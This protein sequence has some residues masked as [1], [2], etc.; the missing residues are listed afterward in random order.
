MTTQFTPPLAG[1]T[2]EPRLAARDL[3]VKFQ[4]KVGGFLA[5][6]NIDLSL[7]PGEFVSLVGAS[8]SGK[9]TLLNVFAGFVPPS[10]GEAHFMGEPITSPSARR[11]VVFQEYGLFPWM[12]IADN[13]GFGLRP[14]GL[15]RKDYAERVN[16]LLDLAQLGSF[17]H[18][19]PHE[20]SGGM[21]QRASLVRALALDP[22]VVLM[23]EPF[24]ALDALTREVL[25]EE[26]LRIWERTGQTVLLIT[27]GVDEAVF[28]S[29]RVIVLDGPPGHVVQE[30]PIDLP[31][32][33][34]AD[35]RYEDQRFLQL[36]EDITHLVRKVQPNS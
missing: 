31:R 17:G 13:I 6:E 19:Y 36:R 15:S 4:T 23:D 8:G 16:N 25:Q 10:S 14:L 9:S 27:H 34:T 30:F 28:M 22:E 11:T 33:R 35:M 12:T 24:G 3:S 1:T 2:S 20:V 29:D 7:A 26:V 18:S 5:L 32:P 21:K